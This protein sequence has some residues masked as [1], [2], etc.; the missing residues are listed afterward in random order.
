MAMHLK[1][2]QDGPAVR[3]LI[4]PISIQLTALL[5]PLEASSQPLTDGLARRAWEDLSTLPSAASTPIVTAV[6]WC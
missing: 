1:R 5:R 6:C 4:T 3:P 2:V